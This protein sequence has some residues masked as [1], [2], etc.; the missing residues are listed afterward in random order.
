MD[1][2][3][4]WYVLNGDKDL[5]EGHAEYERRRDWLWDVRREPYD[6]I[7]SDDHNVWFDAGDL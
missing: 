3:H 6:I 2:Y 7:D 4:V 5:V 1:T